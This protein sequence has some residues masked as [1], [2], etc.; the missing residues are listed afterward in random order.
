[1]RSLRLLIALITPL[2]LLSS[3]GNKPPHL[4]VPQDVIDIGEALNAKADPAEFD[5]EIRN[6]GDQPLVIDNVD[7]SCGCTTV[8]LPEEPIDGGDTYQLHVTFDASRFYP[9]EMTREIK[10]FSNSDDGPHSVFFKVAVKSPY[11][12]NDSCG[13]YIIFSHS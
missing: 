11:V 5:I 8:I 12:A 9:G 10:I 4:E 7:T 2:L 1:M 3:C 6:T 13:T